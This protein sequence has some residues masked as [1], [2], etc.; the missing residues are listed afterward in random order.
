[1]TNAPL[2]HCVTNS[3]P[4]TCPSGCTEPLGRVEKL[5]HRPQ[6]QSLS[7]SPH[8]KCGRNVQLPTDKTRPHLRDASTKVGMSNPNICVFTG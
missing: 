4:C 2:I 1:M 6:C 5:L 3:V 8:R 7:S